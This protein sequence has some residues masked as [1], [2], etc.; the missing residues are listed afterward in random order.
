VVSVAFETMA[1]DDA[2][3]R[4]CFQIMKVEAS[5]VGSRRLLMVIVDAARWPQV[6]LAGVRNHA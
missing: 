6:A 3:T 1:A 4:I 2:I 5:A